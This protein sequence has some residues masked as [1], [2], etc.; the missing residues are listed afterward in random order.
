M[1]INEAARYLGLN[2]VHKAIADRDI[3]NLRINLDTPYT[4]PPPFADL[5]N[6]PTEEVSPSA[7]AVNVL[8]HEM[9]I[10]LGSY[11]IKNTTFML[12]QRCS[13]TNNATQ[14]NDEYAFL[15]T[16]LILGDSHYAD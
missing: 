3:L 9:N 5:L 4:P 12:C 6:L 7:L 15:F 13:I 1:S 10:Q 11:R 8:Q 16:N 14:V 2:P